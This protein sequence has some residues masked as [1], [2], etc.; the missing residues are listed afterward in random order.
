MQVK[1]FRQKIKLD[2]K[3][4]VDGQEHK[5]EE[6]VKFRLDDGDF[7]M[8]CFLS[9]GYVLAD[10]L[11]DNFF[12]F[13]REVNTGFLTP[14]PKILQFDQKEFRFSFKANAVA[15]EV[16]GK[17]IFKV[18]ESETFWDYKAKD[19]SYLSPGIIDKTEARMDFYGKIVKEVELK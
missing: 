8:K 14:F 16:R 17:K 7:Y 11:K 2:S 5:I 13:V 6:I 9:S 1:E 12:V 15:K 4:V 10:D 19:G 18:G 3:V